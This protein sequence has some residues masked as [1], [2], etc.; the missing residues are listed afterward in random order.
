MFLSVSGVVVVWGKG[1][2]FHRKFYF[3][4]CCYEIYLETV[5]KS[6]T[7]LLDFSRQ[8]TYG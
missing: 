5:S 7:V 2:L 8:K 6:G 1:R 4:H 3:C